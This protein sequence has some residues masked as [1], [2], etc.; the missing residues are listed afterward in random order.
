MRGWTEP[1]SL[2]LEVVDG[3][4]I[5]DLRARLQVVADQ[6]V[7]PLLGIVGDRRLVL[8]PSGA[9]AGTP[10]SLL[11]GMAGRPLTIPPSATRWC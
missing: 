11:P 1:A 2:V 7:T 3:G 4:V 8:T 5:A 6:L 10:W 9:L